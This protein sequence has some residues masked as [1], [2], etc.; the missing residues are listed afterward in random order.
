MSTPLSD[1]LESYVSK[2]GETCVIRRARPE[3]GEAVAAIY[4]QYLGKSTF[5]LEAKT[6]AYFA[7]M[8]ARF[9]S[10]GRQ[11]IYIDEAAGR[12]LGWGLIKRYSDRLAYDGACETSTFFDP[13][14]LRQGHGTRM[15]RFLLAECKRLGYHH[16]VA[17]IVAT[18]ESAIR[19]NTLLGYET[20]GV[21]K[22]IGKVDGRFVDVCIMQ[23]LL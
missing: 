22:R 18:N 10:E 12:I 15:K 16:V 17:K 6:G 5:D 23:C 21:Q 7:D 3:D 19:Y 1:V 8:L 4:N 13:A 2:S 20:V 11:E 9:R 14:H